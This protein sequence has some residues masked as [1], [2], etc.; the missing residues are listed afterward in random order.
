MKN[1]E[2]RVTHFTEQ[3]APCDSVFVVAWDDA[4]GKAIHAGQ[5]IDLKNTTQ[6]RMVGAVIETLCDAINETC[7]DKAVKRGLIFASC[8][9]MYERLV[10]E[11]IG[12]QTLDLL[13]MII[14]GEVNDDFLNEVTS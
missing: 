7:A 14:K 6:T 2:K 3:L 12:E 13:T 10:G 11:P 5:L 1:I 8:A 4:E 9:T